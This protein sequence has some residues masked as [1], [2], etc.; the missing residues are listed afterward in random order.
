MKVVIIE[1]EPLMAEGLREEILRI[2]PQVEIVAQLGSIQDSIE[3]LQ[4]EGFPD[5]FF[6]DIELSDGLSFEIFKHVNNT[7]P[8]I[9]CT[10]YNH[11]ALEA[12][13]VY[14]IDY[15][16]KPFS[17]EDIQATL[18][19]YQLLFPQQQEQKIDF[20]AM[21]ELLEKKQAPAQASILVHQGERIIPMPATQIALA[22]LDHGVVYLHT[23]DQ[24]RHPVQHNMDHLLQILGPSF[25]R[26]N[27]Q[28]IIQH[29]AVQHVSQYFARK[30]II[31]PKIE[32]A[33]QLIVS[34]ARVSAFLHW[35]EVN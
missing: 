10:A 35:L 19:K 29:G 6:S 5:L 7:T 33:E 14:G 1:D 4:N 24:K 28:F 32:F 2:D 21:F 23:F 15:L 12:F 31:Q 22:Q 13:Q 9:F 16:L 8:I 30:L 11:Y 17:P 3:H 20:K 27:R 26:V 18:N 25:F 34:K